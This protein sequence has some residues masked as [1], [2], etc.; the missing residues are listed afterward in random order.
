MH[1]ANRSQAC[2]VLLAPSRAWQARGDGLV[3][4]SRGQAAGRIGDAVGVAVRAV[5]RVSLYF[6]ELDF[7]PTPM[8]VLSLRRRRLLT[9]GAD[10]YEIKLGDEFLMSSAFT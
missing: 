6:E 10:V 5:K 2:V 1:P 9:T 7:R 8:G 4:K 3:A